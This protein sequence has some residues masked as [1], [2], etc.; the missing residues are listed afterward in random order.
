MHEAIDRATHAATPS[1]EAGVDGRHRVA[2]QN[3]VIQADR[4]HQDSA[5][6]YRQELEATLAQT[7][8]MPNQPCQGCLFRDS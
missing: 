7:K 1:T 6:R 8:A 3:F 2:V 5:N 4:R